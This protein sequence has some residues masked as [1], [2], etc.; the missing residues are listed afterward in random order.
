MGGWPVTDSNRTLYQSLTS[1]NGQVQQHRQRLAVLSEAGAQ[2]R[3]SEILNND[4]SWF[5]ADNLRFQFEDLTDMYKS[6]YTCQ[7]SGWRYT[8]C[9]ADGIYS[10]Y[11]DGRN[12]AACR[13]AGRIPNQRTL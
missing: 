1:L 11:T 3:Q 5:V 10:Q 6:A 12:A 13:V 8:V 7:A 9:E 4:W 2:L